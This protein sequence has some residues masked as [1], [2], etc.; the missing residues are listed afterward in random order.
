MIDADERI[1]IVIDYSRP[2]F[3]VF[4]EAVKVMCEAKTANATGAVSMA[5]YLGARMELCAYDIEKFL[6]E[7]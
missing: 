4:E 7:L 6:L 2:V 3:E 1:K 5:Y